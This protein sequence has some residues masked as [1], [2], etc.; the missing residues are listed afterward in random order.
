MEAGAEQGPGGAPGAGSGGGWDAF[1]SYSSRDA[2]VAGRIQRF[3][4]RYRLPG[5]GRLRVYRDETDMEGGELPG[6][7]RRALAGSGCLVVCCSEAAA[8]SAWVEREIQA[9]RE[10]APDRPVLPLLVAG[11]APASLPRA[12]RG[13]ELRWADLR[14]GWRLGLPR[15]RTRQELVRAVS[16]VAGIPFRK[17]LPLDRRRRRRTFAGAALASAALAAMV[18]SVPVL[19]WEEVTPPGAGRVGGCG[20]VDEGAVVLYHMNEPQ[21]SASIVNVL[22]GDSVLGPLEQRPVVPRGRLLGGSAARLAFTG[23]YGAR[24]GWAGEVVAG[25]C[26]TLAPSNVRV[27]LVDRNGGT[28]E[29]ATDVVVEDRRATLERKWSGPD[30]DTWDGYGRTVAP[31]RGL[32]VALAGDSVWLGFPADEYL[33]GD[34]WRSG[35]GGDT[36]DKVLGL[37]DVRSLHRSS[38]GLLAAGRWEGELGFWV[39]DDPVRVLAVPGKGDDLEVCGEEGGQPV[40]RTDRSVYRRTRMALWRTW[41]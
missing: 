14:A 18:A 15:R 35:D 38:E 37:R 6:Q 17:L 30:P 10:G 1:L 2:A 5:G 23:C 8:G 33:L 21:A 9:F 28:E 7:I 34:L 40:V 26:M 3:L 27:S 41:L 39:V 25:R 11:D 20:T 32:P 16:A 12:L 19:E 29:P 22:R 13:E 24:D 36:W 31:S 4:E